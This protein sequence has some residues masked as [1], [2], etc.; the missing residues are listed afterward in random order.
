M[1]I[2]LAISIV[3]LVILIIWGIVWKQ[4]KEKLYIRIERLEEDVQELVKDVE[5][6]RRKA[7]EP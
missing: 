5:E 4:Q 2:D 7:G 1:N 3:A 6:L